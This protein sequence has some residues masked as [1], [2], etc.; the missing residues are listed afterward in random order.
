MADIYVIFH[1][2]LG[3]WLSTTATY[4][5]EWREAEKLSREEALRRCKRGYIKQVE[6]FLI[7]PVRWEDLVEME[8]E[9]P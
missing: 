7:I 9:Q 5:S 1:C 6:E 3:A 8:G 4:T 2:K